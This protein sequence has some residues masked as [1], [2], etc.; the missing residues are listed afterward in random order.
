MNNW[1]MVLQKSMSIT[2]RV[3]LEFRTEIYNLFN[4]VQFCQP[5][6]S[7]SDTN[8]FGHSTCEVRRADQTSGARQ[9]QVGMRLRF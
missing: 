7:T 9:I 2:E 4:R 6:N 8:T 5:D 1:D 3:G